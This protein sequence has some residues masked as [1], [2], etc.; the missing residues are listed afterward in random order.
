MSISPESISRSGFDD[1]LSIEVTSSCDNMCRYCF[2]GVSRDRSRMMDLN[3]ALDFMKEGFDLGFRTLHISGG[4]PLLWDHLHDFIHASI[5][6]GYE[7]IYIN[8]NGHMWNNALFNRL[9][10]FKN[11]ISFSITLLGNRSNHDFWRG[12]NTWHMAIK[13]LSSALDAEFPV[14][15]FNVVSRK[16]LES[17]ANDTSSL[18]RSYP[19]L[20]AVTFI[21]LIRTQDECDDIREYILK[22]EDFITFVKSTSFLSLYGYPVHILENPLAVAVARFMGISWFPAASPLEREGHIFLHIDRSLTHAHSVREHSSYYSPG[23]L[24]DIVNSETY[25]KST[26]QDTQICPSC[27]YRKFCLGAGMCRPSEWF[28]TYENTFFCKDVFD[29]ALHEL[30]NNQ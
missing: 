29:H 5:H 1:I 23:S 9:V 11:K 10:D 19:S 15:V 7:S 6:Y 30:N 4:E 27:E 28:R 12:D 14:T 16:N 24:S 13:G 17:I 22:P 20:R 3:I 18:I 25:L 8:S 21:Q 2:T 26:M